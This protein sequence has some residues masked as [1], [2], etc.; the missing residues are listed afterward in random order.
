MNEFPSVVS[1]KESGA[2]GYMALRAKYGDKRL[3]EWRRLGGRKPDASYDQ[4]MAAQ[5][6]KKAAD[7]RTNRRSSSTGRDADRSSA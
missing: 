7:R 6:E 5:A 4:I 3:N 2:R 1:P